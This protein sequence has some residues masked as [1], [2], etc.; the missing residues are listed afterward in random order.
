[1]Y[2]TRSAEEIR[3]NIEKQIPRPLVLDRWVAAHI[4]DTVHTHARGF[5]QEFKNSMSTSDSPQ[6]RQSKTASAPGRS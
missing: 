2:K 5:I 6:T 1:M 4:S 3:L